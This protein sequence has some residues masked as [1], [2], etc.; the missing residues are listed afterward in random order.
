MRVQHK[1][2]RAACVGRRSEILGV[3]QVALHVVGVPLPVE[4]FRLAGARVIAATPCSIS[5]PSLG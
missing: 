3:L 1:T 2:P 5:A 4:I